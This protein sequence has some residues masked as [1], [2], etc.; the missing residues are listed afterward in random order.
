MRRNWNTINDADASKIRV[1]SKG[2]II[3][4]IRILEAEHEK[5]KMEFFEEFEKQNMRKADELEAQL[6]MIREKTRLLDWVLNIN[7]NLN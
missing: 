3:D 1:R 7:P 5:K 4:R 2:E 6:K